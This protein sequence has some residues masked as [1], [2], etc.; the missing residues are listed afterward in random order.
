[1]LKMLANFITASQNSDL[2][3]MVDFI[4]TYKS[5]RQSL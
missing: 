2:K 1:M 5:Q 4:N 3:A